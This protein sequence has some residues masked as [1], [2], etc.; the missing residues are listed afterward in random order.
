MERIKKINKIFNATD[1]ELKK[2][3][4]CETDLVKIQLENQ[5]S[6]FFTRSKKIT[7]SDYE[8]QI[9]QSSKR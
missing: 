2:I 6:N 9:F 7:L 8:K 1:E 3:Y 4:E 5:F